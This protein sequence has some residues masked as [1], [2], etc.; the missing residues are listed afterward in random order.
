MS[1]KTASKEV[2]EFIRG[3]GNVFTDIGLPEPEEALAK[4]RLAEAI[5]QTIER[6]CLT[7]TQAATIM[8]VDQ[9]KVSLIV[10]GRLDGFTQDRLMR[11][12]TNLGDDVEIVVKCAAQYENE[13][14]GRLS[15]TLA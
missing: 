1:R 14:Q 10:N 15:V 11:F 8:G 12:L 9:P 13:D 4:A 2:T 7:Q 3:S 6:R 5:A